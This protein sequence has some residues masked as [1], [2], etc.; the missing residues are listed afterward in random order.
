M[1]GCFPQP[2]PILR[3]RHL[4]SRSLDSG[5]TSFRRRYLALHEV[6]VNTLR[7]NILSRAGVFCGGAVL[8][9]ACLTFII[10]PGLCNSKVCRAFS[11]PTFF[12]CLVCKHRFMD[13]ASCLG[14]K[15]WKWRCEFSQTHEH[16]RRTEKQAEHHRGACANARE[17]TSG[18]YT[19]LGG[20][21]SSL[22][23]SA[24]A[25]R[26]SA[27]FREADPRGTPD[28]PFHTAVSTKHCSVVGCRWFGT[29]GDCG[30][31]LHNIR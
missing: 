5:S 9:C 20:E 26:A 1:E 17:A 28:S 29:S 3:D 24:A 6:F 13:C 30:T 7:D 11:E 10:C 31:R 27:T 21:C 22:E 23:A 14:C 12:Y 19:T 4:I 16:H 18:K 2:L 8:H 15:R 25:W